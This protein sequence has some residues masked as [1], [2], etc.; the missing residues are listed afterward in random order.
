MEEQHDSGWQTQDSWGRASQNEQGAWV[1]RNQRGPWLDSW[2]S[3][4][5][6]KQ[7]P[8]FLWMPETNPDSIRPVDCQSVWDLCDRCRL[9]STKHQ[10]ETTHI[11][12]K[13]KGANKATKGRGHAVRPLR[14]NCA[15]ASVTDNGRTV[16]SH[17][18][19]IVCQKKEGLAQV[20]Q[21]CNFS[22]SDIK[23]SVFHTN[24][25]F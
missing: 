17:V 23:S 24:A 25:F 12:G 13:Q 4:R 18:R 19:L 16:P 6:H 15:D 10:F 7:H 3:W 21:R 5:C 2:K 1:S 22:A 8:I 9:C 20:K 14:L 11:M